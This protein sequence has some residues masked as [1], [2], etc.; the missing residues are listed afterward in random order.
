MN[1]EEIKRRRLLIKHID[2]VRTD[3]DF[4]SEYFLS[5]NEDLDCLEIMRR[6]RAHDLSKFDDL[7]WNHLNGFDDPLFIEAIKHHRLTNDHHPEFHGSIHNMPRIC[8]AEMV[9]DWKAR[10]TQF[11]SDLEQWIEKDAKRIWDFND[12]DEVSKTIKEFLNVLL[13]KPF[14]RN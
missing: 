14:T 3:C 6:G 1:I 9:C 13:E 11:G 4:I 7:E 8:V 12:N 5:N 2:Y 10:S